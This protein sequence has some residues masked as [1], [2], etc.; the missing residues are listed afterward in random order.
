M[1][2]ERWNERYRKTE[3]LWTAEPNRFLVEEIAEMKPGRALDLAAGEGRNAV[4]L[5]ERGWRVTAVEFADEAVNRG[6]R[7]AADR[8]VDVE[9]V[10]ADL[11]QWRPA[12]AAWDLVL[13]LY[14][15]LRAD[16]MATVLERARDGVAPGGT[17]LLVGHDRRN[18]DEGHGG[19]QHSEVLYTADEVARWL[20]GLEIESAETRQR[21]VETDGG[22]V[23]ALDCVVRARR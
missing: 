9:W 23:H 5:A 16:D 7:I 12:G 2:R 15:H 6:R 8:K 10:E 13:V 1:D 3:L 18:L 14:L 22:T 11:L 17:L 21:P 20:T 19:P 4:W